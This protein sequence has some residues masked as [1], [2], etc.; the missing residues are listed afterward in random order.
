MASKFVKK[1][2]LMKKVDGKY[3]AKQ[4][5]SAEF[6]PGQVLEEA[7][8]LQFELED[9]AKNNDKE[10]LKVTM[11]KIYDFIGDSVYEG[12]FTGEEYLN[13]LDAR[14]VMSLTRDI[15]M[16]VTAG[17]DSVYENQKKK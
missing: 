13:G 7:I 3:E 9:A 17:Y 5:S 15:L 6:L 11:R 10:D 4:Y 8:D 2:K 12:Q 1:I 16:S 14:E